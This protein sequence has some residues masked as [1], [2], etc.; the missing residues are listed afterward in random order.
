MT[1]LASPSHLLVTGL[2]CPYSSPAELD[3]W[4]FSLPQRLLP[5]P[6]YTIMHGADRDGIA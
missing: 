3:S 5:P 6:L 2:C 4:Q 1:T